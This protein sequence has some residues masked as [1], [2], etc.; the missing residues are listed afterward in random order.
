MGIISNFKLLASHVKSEIES[1]PIPQ[2]L[3]MMPREMPAIAKGAAIGIAI[4][5]VAGVR[6]MLVEGD[7]LGAARPLLK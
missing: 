2:M 5:P 4:P 1:S 6:A 3:K 7:K